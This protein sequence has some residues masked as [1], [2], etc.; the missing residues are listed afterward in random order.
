MI[1]PIFNEFI[2]LLLKYFWPQ[3]VKQLSF[4]LI[5]VKK[6]SHPVLNNIQMNWIIQIIRPQL[7]TVLLGINY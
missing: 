7:Y 1:V 4:R 6:K 3:P 5:S 2:E